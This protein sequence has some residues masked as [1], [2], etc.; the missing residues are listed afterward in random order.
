[1]YDIMSLKNIFSFAEDFLGSGLDESF[2][3]GGDFNILQYA[4]EDSGIKLEP[5]VN[6]DHIVDE[7]NFT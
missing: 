1:M 5:N 3:N 6:I 2:A 7:V 4:T